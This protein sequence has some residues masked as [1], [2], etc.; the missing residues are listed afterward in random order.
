MAQ[1][2]APASDEEPVTTPT[3]SEVEGDEGV[4]E[5]ELEPP[6]RPDPSPSRKGKGGEG[7]GGGEES[8]SKEGGPSPSKGKRDGSR[9][10]AER[11]SNE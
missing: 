11:A 4:S 3:K 2:A 5:E 9:E 10:R 1:P 8:S 6:R 7:R